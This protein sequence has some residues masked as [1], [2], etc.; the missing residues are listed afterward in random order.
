[1]ICYYERVYNYKFR[2]N[3]KI[4]SFKTPLVPIKSKIDPSRQSTLT[5]QHGIAVTKQKNKVDQSIKDAACL[6]LARVNRCEQVHKNR[7]QRQITTRQGALSVRSA[8]RTNKLLSNSPHQFINGQIKS[9]ENLDSSK[10]SDSKNLGAVI[11]K[12]SGIASA[13]TSLST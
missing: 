1:M 4:D 3:K 7:N 6:E 10:N 12:T 13:S 9:P 5:A 8:K 11:S 2:M